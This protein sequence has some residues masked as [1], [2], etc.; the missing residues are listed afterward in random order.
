[1][2]GLSALSQTSFQVLGPEWAGLFD[3]VSSGVYLSPYVP[4]QNAAHAPI[5]K[6]INDPFP[7][8]GLPIAKGVQ[9]RVQLADGFVAQIKQV[10]IEE[11][12]VMVRFG[13][14]SHVTTCDAAHCVGVVFVLNAQ[15]I[16]ERKVVES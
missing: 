12:Q 2:S 13:F 3:E 10:G 4:Q 16:A 8:P 5:A 1:M 6:I 11:G 9:A 7:E 15:V 14:S